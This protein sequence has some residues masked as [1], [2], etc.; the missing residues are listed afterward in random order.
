MHFLCNSQ[1]LCPKAGKAQVN[2]CKK[3]KFIE[4]ITFYSIVSKTNKCHKFWPQKPRIMID[5]SH[6]LKI[7]PFSA[8]L[9]SCYHPLMNM[10]QGVDI[11]INMYQGVDIL[12]NMYQGVD[13][14]GFP[15]IRE[16]GPQPPCCRTKPYHTSSI[17]K[18][19]CT[20]LVVL[21][22]KTIPHTLDTTP[23]STYH[24]YY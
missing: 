24:D 6:V 11:L 22:N 13:I 20:T 21:Q 2:R 3:G 23:P 17:T 16:A 7:E 5:K 18:Q 9:R 4:F 12:I 8:H 1:S 15:T 10:Y 19:N 14:R